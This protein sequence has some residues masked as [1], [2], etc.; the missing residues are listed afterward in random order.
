[1]DALLGGAEPTDPYDFAAVRRWCDRVPG[2]MSSLNKIFIPVNPNDNHWNF[3][4]VRV[5]AKRIEMWDSLGLQTS[6]AKYLAAAERFVKDALAREEW[7]GRTAA[8][9]GW[10]VGWGSL[11]RSGD[12]LR[13]G[14][15]Y[16]CRIFMLTSMSL[17]RIGLRL[18]KE[19][20]TQGTLTLRRTRKRL[21]EHVWAMEV[22]SKDTRWSSQGTSTATCNEASLAGRDPGLRGH[23]QKRKQGTE[24][25]LALGNTTLRRRWWGSKS[26]QPSRNEGVQQLFLANLIPCKVCW[27]L[28][29]VAKKM[30]YSLLSS[31]DW[32]KDGTES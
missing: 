4:R 10:H 30:Q 19:A 25:R 28:T 26:G 14:N 3:I 21:A 23:P 1:M 7:A 20:Y 2:G 17:V 5:Q 22:N 32:E 15:G 9:Q 8:D 13:Q 11:D 24:G 18:S 12:S 16:D 27:R 6:N 31:S 29:R